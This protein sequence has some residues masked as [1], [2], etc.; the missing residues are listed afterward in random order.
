MKENILCVGETLM[1]LSTEMGKHYYD[2]T[3]LHLHYGGAEANVAVNLSNL[4]HQTTYFTKVPD[5]QLGRAAIKHVT[6][7][8]VDAKN[9][10]FGGPRMG[11]YYLEAGVG[12]RPTTVIYDRANSSVSQLTLE[13]VNVEELLEG[14]TML[15]ITG[16]TAALSENMSEMTF[17]LI[18][19]AKEKGLKVNYDVNYRAKLWSI[20]ESA[21]FLKRVLPYVDYLS[22]GK[23]DAINFL[24]IQQPG[25]EVTDELGYY[26]NEIHKL[27][28][29]IEIIYSTLR[30]VIS[31][32]H[33]T[34][35]GAIWKD[36][37]THYSKVH[38]MDYIIDR[39][40]GGDAFAAG[41]LHGILSD[42]EPEYT[43][44]FATAFSVLKHTVYGDACPF[45]IEE[46]ERIMTRDARVDR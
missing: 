29:N 11:S 34:L 5:N 33:N 40:G 9:V 36:G 8:G 31:A 25:E 32:T 3:S 27:Y 13:E 43:I 2:T 21:A 37:E 12:A 28:P 38:D 24:G 26:Y 18:Q 7:Y 41:V 44:N 15:H 39:I 4:N 46:A 35:Q 6:K 1:R 42:K 19:K 20:E 22:A 14:K 16:I 10:I 45:T 30:N 23:L 17:Q